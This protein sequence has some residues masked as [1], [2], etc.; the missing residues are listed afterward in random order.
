MDGS[1]LRF[2]VL[3]TNRDLPPHHS[4]Y[5]TEMHKDDFDREFKNS[6]ITALWASG[7]HYFR[8]L[9]VVL[10]LE[11][12]ASGKVIPIPF[13]LDTGAP[14][15]MNLGVG[16]LRELFKKGMVQED[17]TIRLRGNLF[18]KNNVIYKPMSSWPISQKLPATLSSTN[19]LHGLYTT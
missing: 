3:L 11:V 10:P 7:S 15:V 9:T 1:E 18:W 19:G 14:T 4:A 2:D 5:L 8:R 12:P 17:A 13:I 6:P 16:A